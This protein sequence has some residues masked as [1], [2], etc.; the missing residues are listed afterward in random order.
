MYILAKNIDFFR[1]AIIKF[2]IYFLLCRGC[3]WICW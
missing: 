2:K 3:M 1:A